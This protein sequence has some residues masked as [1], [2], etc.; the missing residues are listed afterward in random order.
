MNETNGGVRHFSVRDIV[1][2]VFRRKVPVTIVMVVVAAAALTAA[3]RTSSVY[4]AA[5]KVFLRRSGPTPLATSWTP[6]YGLEEEM[7]TEVEIVRSVDVMSRAVEILNEKGV[8]FESVVGDSVVRREPTIGDI[9]AGLSATPI[10]Q[11]NVILVRYTG[12]TPHFVQEAAN[13][14]AEAYVQ[15]RI[16]VRSASGIEQYFRDQLGLLEARLLD[17]ITAELE[18]MKSA[19]IYDLEWQYQMTI[20]RKT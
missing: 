1:A 3:S 11:S 18:L 13:A 9:S 5:A 4:E 10:E 20:N 6:F 14:A 2:V 16:Q 15:H 7:N 12:T 17:L 19:N 8:F